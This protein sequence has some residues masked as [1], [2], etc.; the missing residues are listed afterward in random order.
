MSELFLPGYANDA[1]VFAAIEHTAKKANLRQK[2]RWRF[3]HLF[4]CCSSS[5]THSSWRRSERSD[6]SSSAILPQA[7][8]NDAVAKSSNPPFSDQFTQTWSLSWP[9]NPACARLPSSS[10]TGPTTSVGRCPRANT[11]RHGSA[12]VGFSGSLPV[13]ASRLASANP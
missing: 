13:S 9:Q 2:L 8:I 6:S 5:R 3:A 10:R 1:A 4:L 11:S 12:R 7:V